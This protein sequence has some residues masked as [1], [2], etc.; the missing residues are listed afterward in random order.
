MTFSNL[1]SF[2]YLLKYSGFNKSVFLSRYSSNPLSRANKE[3]NIVN[4][5]GPTENTTFSAY[6]NIKDMSQGF[7]PIGFPLANSTG[8]VVFYKSY[9]CFVWHHNTF[10]FSC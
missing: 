4:G 10:W 3:L 7:I 8:Y 6:Y 2:I 1:F 9:Y 5:Y